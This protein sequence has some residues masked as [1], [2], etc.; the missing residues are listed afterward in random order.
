MSFSTDDNFNAMG[1][2][3]NYH[4][5]KIMTIKRSELK[6]SSTGKVFTPQRTDKDKSGQQGI[7]SVNVDSDLMDTR[8]NRSL[9]RSDSTALIVY[10]T[11]NFVGDVE[12]MV[13]ASDTSGE[14]AADTMMLTIENINDAPF[15]SNSMDD[16]EVDEDSEPI[17]LDINGV[18]D[19]ADILIGDS[20]TITAQSLAD[21]LVIVD[22]DSNSVPVLLFV[23]NG[24]GETDIVVT[25]TDIAGLSVDDTVHV[26]VVS[27]ND[28]PGD[29]TLLSPEHDAT[30]TITPDN[31]S[32][33][34]WFEWT[35]S[36]DIDG[37]SLIYEFD[38]ST[39]L[40][41]IE[42]LL[43]LEGGTTAWVEYSVMAEAVDAVDTVSGDWSLFV[44]DGA[45]TVDAVNGAFTVTID[46]VAMS[47]DLK[48][49][50]PDEFA[51]YQ[52]YPNPFNPVTLIKY[53]LPEQSHVY[54]IIYDML[55]RQV[56]TLIN[57]NQDA[58]FKSMKWDANDDRGKPV[59]AG[60]YI[61][62]IQAGEFVQT[63]KMVLLK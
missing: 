34:L 61:Y 49:L 30:I 27:V 12:I 5:I 14:F 60:V 51:L 57:Q 8:K 24:H 47:V 29:F 41:F 31:I 55:G 50:I 53:D 33:T 63:R 28:A 4:G 16:M 42:G 37:D 44:T 23:E 56:R 21:T 62:Q 13:V 20:L 15:V 17:T 10:P 46:A 19:D 1:S 18:F 58:G 11:E 52:N 43:Q 59:S 40:A 45:D 2:M 6:K 26:I 38:A 25:A 22:Y 3:S 9:S 39:D 7:M 48:E 54:I 32:D 35:A 36:I